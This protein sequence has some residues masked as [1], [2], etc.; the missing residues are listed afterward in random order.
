MDIHLGDL[1]VFKKGLYADEEDAIYRVLEINGDRVVIELV[2]TNMYIPPQS[3][4]ILNDLDK[5]PDSPPD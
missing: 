3:I 4:A 5:L 2:S 1:V